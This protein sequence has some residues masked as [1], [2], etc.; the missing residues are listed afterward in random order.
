MI[1]I[2]PYLRFIPR[3]SLNV[4]LE[5]TSGMKVDFVVFKLEQFTADG[6][7]IEYFYQCECKNFGGSTF[8]N[9]DGYIPDEVIKEIEEHVD[10]KHNK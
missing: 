6:E 1:K 10:Y 4:A 5:L 2:Q 8:V 7:V 9:L 3:V